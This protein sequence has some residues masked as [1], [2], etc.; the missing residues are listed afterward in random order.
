MA[1]LNREWGA[2]CQVQAGVLVPSAPTN[3]TFAI[4]GHDPSRE[5]SCAK[6]HPTPEPRVRVG[7][8]VEQPLER[9]PRSL[10]EAVEAEVEREPLIPCH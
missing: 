2:G 1:R 6:A 3:H 4:G 8:V 7:L 10:A 9:R 5:A